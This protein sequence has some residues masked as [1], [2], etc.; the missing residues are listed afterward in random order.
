MADL[1]CGKCDDSWICEAHPDRA[2]P[3]DDCAGPGHAVRR[4]GLP[5]SD[6]CAP[7]AE[8]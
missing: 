2:W 6:G 3:P 7:G 1:T 5:V 8:V 4:A